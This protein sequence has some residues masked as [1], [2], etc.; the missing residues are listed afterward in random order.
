M[1]GMPEMPGMAGG[2]MDM[3]RM[4]AIHERMMADPVIRERVASDPVLQQMMLGMTGGEPPLTEQE[5]REAMEFIVRLLSDPQVEARVHQDPALHRL[6]AN[7]QVQ[8]RLQELRDQQPN[9]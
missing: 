2:A 6:W 9:R 4:M 8:A 5:R 1:P 3:A 7:P